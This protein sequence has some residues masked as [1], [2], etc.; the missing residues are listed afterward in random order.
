MF[1][2]FLKI[3]WRVILRDKLQS[4]IKIMGLTV[5]SASVLVISLFVFDQ[6]SYDKGIANTDT[7]YRLNTFIKGN[8]GNLDFNSATASPPI[9]PTMKEE[10][11]GIVSAVRII[12]SEELLSTDTH[13]S[14]FY[15]QNGYSCD[16]DFFEIFNY[17]VLE[18]NGKTALADPDMIVLSLNLKE[19]LFGKESALGKV[20]YLGSGEEK[21]PLTV[22]AVFD[23]STIKSHLNP[24]YLLSMQTTG[25]G[26]FVFTARNWVGQNFVSQY[27][28]LEDHADP[29]IVESKANRLLQDKAADDLKSAGVEKSLRLQPLSDIFLFSEG[30]ENNLDKVSS[31]EYLQLLAGIA[32]F[33][34]LMASANYI[35]LATSQ[36]IKRS[37]EIGVRKVNGASAKLLSSQ[38]LTESFLLVAISVTLSIPLVYLILPKFNQL[39]GANLDYQHLLDVR[40]AIIIALLVLFSGFISG[41][42][43]AFYLSKLKP[44]HMFRQTPRQSSFQNYFKNGLVIFQFAIVFV[45]IFSVLLI[46]RQIDF[47][48]TRDL[49]FQYKNKLVLPL[50]TDR[51]AKSFETLKAELNQLSVLN[52]ITGVEFIPST[53]VLYD[54]RVY[55]KAENDNNPV[56]VKINLVSPGY[57]RNMSVMLLDGR[58]VS[59]SD[60]N[61]VIVNEAFLK[62]FDLDL[63]SAVG[64]TF[65]TKREGEQA[66]GFEIIGIHAD[67][68][69]VSLKEPVVPTMSYYSDTPDHLVC[70]SVNGNATETR[71]ALQAVWAKVLPDEPFELKYLS[72]QI[73]SMY[74]DEAQTQD[75]GTIFSIIAILL[76]ILGIWGLVSHAMAARFK[77]IGI[78]K[79]LGAT[80]AHVYFLMSK[81]YLGSICIA[82]LLGLPVAWYF[83]DQWLNSYEYKIENIQPPLLIAFG[84]T[85]LIAVASMSYSIIK[86]ALVNP[87]E[88][89]RNE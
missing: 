29:R 33:I 3:S 41:S 53:P 44:T 16:P 11:P 62:A 59:P 31:I 21:K 46:H 25:L 58:D 45:L 49:G 50:K 23:P 72:D 42:Y 38:F 30:I 12:K 43:P 15:E 17:P 75:I 47:I 37:K 63:N 51:A 9:A 85:V 28:K 65:Y 88:T 5:G 68:N 13:P 86:A 73:R 18:G 4:V 89:L 36:T 39:T 48:N 60:G 82:T 40:V 1:K 69:Q 76:G 24:S 70:T 57:Y 2:S 78:R 14:G 77:E 87:V 34:L 54:A 20:I 64:S 7:V 81:K 71:E 79:V 6:L 26:Q 35:N 52:G 61:Q 56:G 10:I 74:A 19:K 27:L 80:V 84:L 83:S 22:T 8:G 55:Q 67:F 66:E 32:F